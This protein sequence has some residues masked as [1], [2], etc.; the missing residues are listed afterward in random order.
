MVAGCMGASVQTYGHA[1]SVTGSVRLKS[2]YEGGW[3]KVP[4]NF[5]WVEDRLIS[6]VASLPTLTP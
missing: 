2:N 4:E 5:R 1:H 3:I 6:Y